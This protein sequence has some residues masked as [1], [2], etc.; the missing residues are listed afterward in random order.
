MLRI[1]LFAAASLAVAMPTNAAVLVDVPATAMPWDWV[2]GGLN[3]AY[4]FGV[5]DGTAPVVVDFAAAGAI[6]G[7]AVLYVS[8]LTS[9][10]AGVAPHVGV[11]GYDYLN[12]FKDGA[13]G[14]SGTYLPSVYMPGLWSSVD[15]AGVFLNA[16]SW[17]FTDDTGAIVAG[18]DAMDVFYDAAN[19]SFGYVFG[20][21]SGPGIPGNATR[22]SFGLNDDSFSDNSGSLKVCVGETFAACDALIN[23]PVVPEPATWALL[24]GGF[25]LVGG[26]LRRRR[27]GIATA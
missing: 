25:G 26:A 3:D 15:G 8:G 18:P 13:L 10:F 6:N 9:A 2:A 12:N 21:S 11:N 7:W 22:I 5:Q 17:A 19:D 16:L 24:I 27:G 14:S 1:A 20:K 4:Q 23:P